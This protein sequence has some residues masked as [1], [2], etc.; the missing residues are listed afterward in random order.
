MAHLTL[1]GVVEN[2]R[3]RL[4]GTVTLPEHAKVYVVV[5]DVGAAS[6]PHIHSPRLAHRRQAADFSKKIIE[7]SLDL[8]LIHISEPTRPY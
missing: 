6:Q 2:G 7:A 4:M 5:P 1:E 8:S 3:V